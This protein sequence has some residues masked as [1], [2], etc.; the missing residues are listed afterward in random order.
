ME[1][2]VVGVQLPTVPMLLRIYYRYTMLNHKQLWFQTMRCSCLE[3]DHITRTH[4]AP[5]PPST[6][7]P[8]INL[9]RPC[10]PPRVSNNSQKKNPLRSHQGREIPNCRLDSRRAR[11]APHCDSCEHHHPHSTASLLRVRSFIHVCRLPRRSSGKLHGGGARYRGVLP[12]G[13]TTCILARHSTLNW[14]SPLS[15]LWGSST[16]SQSQHMVTWTWMR[17]SGNM[18]PTKMSILRLAREW[19]SSAIWV[20]KSSGSNLCTYNIYTFRIKLTVI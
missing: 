6:S 16:R 19:G 1:V 12:R 18:T 7:R 20:W 15:R 5:P 10:N 2:V 13:A 8:T 17:R 3:A 9:V 14:Y 4:M 11:R